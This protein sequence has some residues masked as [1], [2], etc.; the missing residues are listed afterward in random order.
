MSVIRKSKIVYNFV[1]LLLNLSVKDNQRTLREINWSK[2]YGLRAQTNGTLI[3]VVLPTE[4]LLPRPLF[5][6]LYKMPK[7]STWIRMGSRDKRGLSSHI[8]YFHEDILPTLTQNIELYTSDGDTNIPNDLSPSL[9]KDI[10]NHQ[11]ITT[12]YAQNLNTKI[13]HPKLKPIP[14]G[15]DLHTDQGSGVGTRALSHYENNASSSP[16][17]NKILVDCCLN[18]TNPTRKTIAD[19]FHANPNFEFLKTRLSQRAL[20]ELYKTYRYVLSIEGNGYD[21][22][23][24]YEALQFNARVVLL[25]PNLYNLHLDNP[26][27]TM[28]RSTEE[29]QAF[30]NSISIIG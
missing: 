30:A 16:R 1:K 26:N 3:N 4:A 12:W 29:L 23:R 14:I 24:T 27:I 7:S 28:L 19:Q 17:V 13:Q 11:H 22:H 15:I 20:H 2:A 8:T 5:R 25:S 21:C 6:F 9:V 10:L 18:I